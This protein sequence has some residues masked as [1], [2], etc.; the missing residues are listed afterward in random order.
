MD[1]VTAQVP[2]FAMVGGAL[3]KYLARTPMPDEAI[4]SA[5]DWVEDMLKRIRHGDTV[6]PE[7][8]DA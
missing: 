1:S 8:I 2:Q 5:L 7:S 6:E 3:R 4:L